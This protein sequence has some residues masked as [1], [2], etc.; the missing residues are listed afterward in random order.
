V[1]VITPAPVSIIKAVT[2]TKKLDNITNEKPVRTAVVRLY[3][4]K[5]VARGA[6]LAA[7]VAV[8]IL[9]R[10]LLIEGLYGGL[11]GATWLLGLIWFLFAAEMLL[12]FFPSKYESMGSQKQF[13]DNFAAAGRTITLNAGIK[14]KQARAVILVASAWIVLNAGVGGLYFTGIIDEGGLLII[15]LF[16]AVSDAVCILFYCPFQSL[17]MKNRCC[18]DCRIY[19]WD[20]LM[21]FTPLLFI[22]SWYTLSLAGIA[23]L[24][25]VRWET[26][27]AANPERFYEHTNQNLACSRCSENLC[28]Y[29][30]TTKKRG[31]SQYEHN[32]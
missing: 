2:I 21:M 28:K 25:L 5:L 23:L 22:F 27:C 8:Y 6:L 12:R 11:N 24:L 3:F 15:S 10:S 19:N 16:Y 32:G 13:S 29:K 1:L 26:A 17:I 7:A 30:Q 14:R 20:F 18:I 9:D 31:E 4:V